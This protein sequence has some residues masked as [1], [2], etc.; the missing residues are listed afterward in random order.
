MSNTPPMRDFSEPAP[1]ERFDD[2][3]SY[4][5]LIE[6]SEHTGRLADRCWSIAAGTAFK[7]SSIMLRQLASGLWRATYH[8]TGV[9]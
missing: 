6:L 4:R 8:R 3:Q 7:A 2:L 9:D 5:R 1:G